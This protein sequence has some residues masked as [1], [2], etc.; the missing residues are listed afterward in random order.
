MRVI[1]VDTV[2]I[3]SKYRVVIPKK[4]RE[5]LQLEPGAE[6]HVYILDGTIRLS[7]L[8]H[9]KDLRGMAKGMTWKDGD[10]DRTERF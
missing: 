6:L 8:R 1:P 10:R 3:S 9:V 5:Q 7:R 2:R 4:I